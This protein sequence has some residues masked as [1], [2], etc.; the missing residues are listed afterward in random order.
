MFPRLRKWLISSFLFQ[1][2]SYIKHTTCRYH[3]L[4]KMSWHHF[5]LNPL[6]TLITTFMSLYWYW[7]RQLTLKQVWG[8]RSGL[9]DVLQVTT[10][11]IPISAC[12]LFGVTEFCNYSMRTSYL[13]L[14]KSFM[15][16]NVRISYWAFIL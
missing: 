9:L 11:I 13:Y 15:F 12:Y 6:S 5:V 3:S 4:N 16:Y 14:T 1:I 10:L 8:V 7:G 2:R